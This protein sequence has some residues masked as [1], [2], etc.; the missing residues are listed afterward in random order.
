MEL[1]R[2]NEKLWLISN[3]LEPA[4]CQRLVSLSEAYGYTEALVN[5]PAGARKMKGIRNND[6]LLREDE[7]LAAEL[8]QKLQPFCPVR[9]DNTLAVGLN[10]LFRFYKYG[11]GQ[12]FKKHRDGRF[13]RNPK[14][15]SRI[16]VLVYLNQG[17]TGGETAFEE[18]V[19]APATGTAVCFFH[20]LR[21]EGRPVESGIKYVLRSDVMYRQA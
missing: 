13:E 18:V 21:H 1:N 15:A 4:Q 17:F 10:E 20:E 12:R 5:L 14:E 3:F 8:W 6:R 11:A 7:G 2:I 19:L 16:T 9:L